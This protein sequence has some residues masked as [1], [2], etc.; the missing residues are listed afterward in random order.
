MLGPA[1]LKSGACTRV[2][3][4]ERTFDGVRRSGVAFV[5]AL[6]VAATQLGNRV[7]VRPV[8]SATIQISIDL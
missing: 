7:L 8:T 4:V 2:A 6:C 3:F 5:N 1:A